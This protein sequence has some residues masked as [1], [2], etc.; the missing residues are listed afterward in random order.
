MHDFRTGTGRHRHQHQQLLWERGETG[1]VELIGTVII[2]TL[3]SVGNLVARVYYDVLQT[4]N[5]VLV[6]GIPSAFV[7]TVL[8]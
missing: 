1:A 4:G 8:L 2:A 3:V 7:G 6:A 5:M